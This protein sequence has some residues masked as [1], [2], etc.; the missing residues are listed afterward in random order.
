MRPEQDA[1]VPRHRRAQPF[2]LA[3]VVVDLRVE[4]ALEDQPT[5]RRHDVDE[6]AAPAR[7]ELVEDLVRFRQRRLRSTG[8][9]LAQPVPEPAGG[10]DLLLHQARRLVPGAEQPVLGP[11]QGERSPA[12]HVA[13]E[14][15]RV[16]AAGGL[17]PLLPQR[18]DVG[19]LADQDG[20]PPGLAGQD[21]LLLPLARMI[22]IM[23]RQ[24]VV[25]PGRAP[26]V[27]LG[28]PPGYPDRRQ[29]EVIGAV[30]QRLV[31]QRGGRRVARHPE[32]DRRAAGPAGGSDALADQPGF[33]CGGGLGEQHRSGAVGQQFGQLVS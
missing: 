1:R 33:C 25:Q 4:A 11:V 31:E 26:A 16:L 8:P 7:R 27:T 10:E 9:E 29:P 19:G 12:G 3:L 6:P 17:R 2:D 20:S 21:P 22:G 18:A 28:R 15:G 24:H 14:A 30:E 23:T 32:A 5:D 13:G